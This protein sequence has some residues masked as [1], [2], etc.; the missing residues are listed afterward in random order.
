MTADRHPVQELDDVVHQRAR[1]G[2]LAIL[3][4]VSEAD[5]NTI[6]ATLELTAGNLSQHL[7]TL[8]DR[9]YISQRKTFED[10][11]PRTW[12]RATAKGRKAF[13]REIDALRSLIARHDVGRQSK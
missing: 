8:E 9:G 10:K 5:F 3:C 13:E 4:E 12:V 2:V 1:L 7:S 11:R 6:R